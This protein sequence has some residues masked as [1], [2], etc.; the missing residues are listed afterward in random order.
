MFAKY[1]T[2]RVI[3]NARKRRKL[4]RKP[5]DKKRADEIAERKLLY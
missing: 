3:A 5:C 2:K 1:K 4:I